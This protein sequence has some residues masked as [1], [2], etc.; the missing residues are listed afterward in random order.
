[1]KNKY[2]TDKIDQSD[3]VPE[4]IVD[5][6]RTDEVKRFL[7]ARREF[8]KTDNET[9]ADFAE[10]LERENDRLQ[11]WKTEAMLVLG[12]WEEAWEA[13]GKPGDLGSSKAE[14]TRKYIWKMRECAAELA[15]ALEHYTRGGGAVGREAV[16]L[17]K[18]INLENITK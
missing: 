16:R 9:W 18:K 7:R 5:T 15:S 2:T 4:P 6:P 10:G 17:W 12:K 13:A 8:E 1:M 14:S 3:L 11:R